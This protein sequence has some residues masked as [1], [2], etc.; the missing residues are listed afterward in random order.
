MSNITIKFCECGCG[1]IIKS[2]N[3]RFIIGHNNKG[4]K[5]NL[6]DEQ[7][8]ILSK[9]AKERMNNPITKKKHSEAV[10]K[11]KNTPEGK[12]SNRRASKKGNEVI[13]KKLLT[14]PEFKKRKSE[15]S[16]KNCNKLWKERKDHMLK[17]RKT[18]WDENARKHMSDSSKKRFENEEERNELKERALK[19]FSN[20][21][22]REKQSIRISQAYLDG[23]LNYDHNKYKTGY[24]ITI[25]GEK[26]FFQSSYEERFMN[27]LEYYFR[28]MW[29]RSY[30]MFPYK[31]N[32]ITKQY[33]PDFIIDDL[34]FFETKGWFSEE[35]KN[36]IQSATKISNLTVY[37][38][39]E[40]ELK[41][42]EKCIENNIVKFNF[43]IL[44]KYINGN[45]IKGNI[46]RKISYERIK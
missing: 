29:K 42:F 45:F 9:K 5:L 4:K 1:Q 14:D 31:E 28:N 15:N 36:K 21:E 6:T 20:I 13:K 12:E 30:K 27:I 23:R 41:Y 32:E 46:N 24:F 2:K 40:E 44:S 37:M 19:R 17:V 7:R 35:D 43:E 8:S 34:F 10:K 11:A 16:R 18:Q 22:E 25:E 38:I 39:F 26:I 33:V 3:T